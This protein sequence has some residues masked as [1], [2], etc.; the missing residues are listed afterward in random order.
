[1][2]EKDIHFRTENGKD[3]D[4]LGVEDGNKDTRFRR[5]IDGTDSIAKMVGLLRESEQEI[6]LDSNGKIY[7]KDNVISAL[8][9]LED[10]LLNTPEEEINNQETYDL[11]IKNLNNIPKELNLRQ[12]TL[13]LL[14]YINPGMKKFIFHGFN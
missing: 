3:N 8:N 11:I 13:R 2:D 10:I 12:Q 9:N 7:T 5:A 1:M 6:V 14:T 4:L